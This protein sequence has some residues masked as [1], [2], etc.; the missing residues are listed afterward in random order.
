MKFEVNTSLFIKN[1]C[2]QASNSE[3]LQNPD[4]LEPVHANLEPQGTCQTVIF[5]H[6]LWVILMS[7]RLRTLALND[8]QKGEQLGKRALQARAWTDS[9][10]QLCLCRGALQTLRV[11]EA[12]AEV[13]QQR[14]AVPETVGTS[15]GLE[16]LEDSTLGMSI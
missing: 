1:C 15:L 11:T 2:T 7:G 3:I 6:V 8:A 5:F 9:S 4:S 13:P 16:M 10:A 12:P 14:Q